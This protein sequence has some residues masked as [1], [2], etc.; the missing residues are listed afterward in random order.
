MHLTG[1]EDSMPAQA[2]KFPNCFIPKDLCDDPPLTIATAKLDPYYTEEFCTPHHSVPEKKLWAACLR[3]ALVELV[4][5]NKARA[6]K[7]RRWVL[8]DADFIGS[9]TYCCQVLG[10]APDKIRAKMLGWALGGYVS[11]KGVW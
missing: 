8:D 3:W 6:A 1:L 4:G 7:T 5:H 9:F 2:R 11:K 10:L